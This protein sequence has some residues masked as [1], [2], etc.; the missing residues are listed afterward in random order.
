MTALAADVTPFRREF[1]RQAL[2]RAEPRWLRERREQALERFEAKGF[3]T[4]RDEAWRGTS[5]APIA[6]TAWQPADG[7]RRGE[8]V[9]AALHRLG[10][11]E[12]FKGSE[13][14]FVNGRYAPDLS[15][16]FDVHGV[17]V[18]SL[19]EALAGDGARLQG[20]LGR[21]AS[22]PEHPFLALN[23][24]LFEDGV[25]LF[26]AAGLH[27]EK[28][29]HVLHLSTGDGAPTV[30]HPRTLLVVGRGSECTLVESYGGPAEER[31][32][33]NAVTEVRL[34]DGASLDHSTLERQSLSA[35]HVAS[36]AVVLG[37]DARYAN[38]AVTVGAALA[39]NDIGVTLDAPGADAELLGLFVGAGE[40]HLDAHTRIDHAKPHGTSREV[41]KGI[42][43]GSARGVFH[44][45]IVVRKDAQK[46][47]AY[48][49]NKNLLLS[50]DALVNSTPQL[51]ILADDVKCK[52][53]STT[54]QLEEG[55]LFYLQS[56]GIS[57]E[58]ARGLLTWAFASDLVQKLKLAPVRISL[59]AFLHDRL[60]SLP[61]E[62]VA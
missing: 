40:Q 25:A 55:A 13:I 10:F 62:A 7:R 5:V 21:L 12:A 30:S 48:Q 37:R 43:N 29:I 11:A 17:E 15:S 8:P 51:E 34:E 59:E 28:P 47:D 6:H 58:A 46:T 50:R 52:H 54:G 4:P 61:K 36:L 41:Y 42:L 22:D 9:V 35:H 19:R 60:T 32:F 56:R 18:V 16:F 2:E 53:G 26:V 44:G 45:R 14:V 23:T 49:T 38:H 1:E 24:A 33:T 20:E 31:Y 39:R 27:V 3:P 57:L